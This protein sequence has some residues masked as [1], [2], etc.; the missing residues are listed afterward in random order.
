MNGTLVGAH[1]L[2]GERCHFPSHL[3]AIRSNLASAKRTGC[4]FAICA[5]SDLPRL[6][7]RRLLIHTVAARNPS[8]EKPDG[9][10]VDGELYILSEIGLRG[11]R[12]IQDLAFRNA[13]LGKP[14]VQCDF[15]RVHTV[16]VCDCLKSILPLNNA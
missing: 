6:F 14:I 7:V 3:L 1:S 9:S 8:A 15:S 13:R 12:N 10:I 11:N 4:I 5:I 2:F 16:T